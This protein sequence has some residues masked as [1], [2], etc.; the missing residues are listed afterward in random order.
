VATHTLAAIDISGGLSSAWTAIANFVP[1]L[2]AFL[3]IL[4]IGWIIAKVLGKVVGVV[5]GKVGFDRLVERGGLKDMLERNN[6]KGSTLVAKVVYYAILLIALEVAFGAFGPNPISDI[7]TAI[8]GWL[9]KLIVA[10]LIIV[11]VGA[12]ANA[13]RNLV[14]GA[15]SGLSYGRMLGSIA[16]IFI[17]GMGIIAA[18]NQ[19]GIA[20]AVTTPVLIT[21]LATIGGVVVVGMGGGLIMPMRQRWGTWIGRMESQLPEARVHAEAYQR[22]Q[23]D[24][25][26]AG[27]Q[28]MEPGAQ[29]ETMGGGTQQMPPQQ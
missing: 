5:L 17:W 21:V 13:V 25:S 24:M 11:I 2:V 27:T 19:M 12:I 18:L 3:V 14:G 16:A 20:T 15:L 23:E 8:V 4:L 7:L 10:M 9:P 6:W 26:R 1:K 28:P 22:G 29:R